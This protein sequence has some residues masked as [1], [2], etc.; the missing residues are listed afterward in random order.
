MASNVYAF[1][2]ND[3]TQRQRIS[4]YQ[5]WKLRRL[6]ESVR[7]AAELADELN[8]LGATDKG[9]QRLTRFVCMAADIADE[10]DPARGVTP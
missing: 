5:E 1:P 9:L 3:A 8:E 6:L 2:A 7:V 4:G 10:I